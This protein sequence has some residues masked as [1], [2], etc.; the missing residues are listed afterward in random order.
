MDQKQKDKIQAAYDKTVE[1]FLNGISPLAVVPNSFKQSK[2]F[3]HFLRDTDPALTG[4]EAPEI[5]EFLQPA[6]GDKLLDV[7]CCA[8]LATK[9]FDKWPS[10]YFGIDISPA[11]IQ[12]MQNFV[13]E[14]DIT[15]GGLEIAEMTALPYPDSIFDLAMVIGVFEYVDMDY[16]RSAVRELARV[17]K[18]G[19]RLVADLPNPA[20]PHLL[21][22]FRLEEYLG[23]PNILKSR[24][25]FEKILSS[26]FRIVST[27]DSQVMIKYFMRKP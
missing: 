24:T 23:R 5:M 13:R 20:H 11:L 19:A 7:G 2:K 12:A 25:S 18:P 16:A 17:L 4:S 15:I 6:E 8:N 9:R 10:L 26:C 27:D 22:M 21:T 3:R 14:A 1:D